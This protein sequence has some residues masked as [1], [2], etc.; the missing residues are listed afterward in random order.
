MLL[1]E[2]GFL[3]HPE[4]RAVRLRSGILPRLIWQRTFCVKPKRPLRNGLHHQG[5]LFKT[6]HSNSALCQAGPLEAGLLKESVLVVKVFAVPFTLCVLCVL[7]G[8]SRW[9]YGASG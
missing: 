1:L 8:E 3:R 5:T 2:A 7:C 4:R 6:V 9:T